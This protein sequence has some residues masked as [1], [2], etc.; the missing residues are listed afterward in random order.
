MP[1][2]IA[3][4]GIGQLCEEGKWRGLPCKQGN[5]VK[6]QKTKGYEILSLSTNT[7]KARPEATS[8]H[9]WAVSGIKYDPP[10]TLLRAYL[11]QEKY[12]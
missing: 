7:D 4:S 5:P 8:H 3:S 2:G 10:S 6:Q 9:P 1:C 12:P 11:P